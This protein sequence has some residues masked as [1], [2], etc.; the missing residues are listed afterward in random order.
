MEPTRDEMMAKARAK[1]IKKPTAQKAAEDATEAAKA[2]PVDKGKK[3][4]K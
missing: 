3:P 4:A 2:P 1:R